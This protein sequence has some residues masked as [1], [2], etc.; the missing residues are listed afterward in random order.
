[1][2]QM[3]PTGALA[4]KLLIKTENYNKRIVFSQGKRWLPKDLPIPEKALPK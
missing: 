4:K 1:M 3:V 2:P